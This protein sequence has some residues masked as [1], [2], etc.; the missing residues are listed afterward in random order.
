MLSNINDQALLVFPA[1][2]QHAVNHISWAKEQGIR[3]V[4]ASSDVDTDFWIEKENLII[5]PYIYSKDFPDKFLTLIYNENVGKIYSP[6]VSVYLWLKKFISD[7]GLR[8]RL[9]GDSP[10]KSEMNRVD[11]LLNKVRNFSD[12]ITDCSDGKSS[13]S[14][15]E[16][17][18]VFRMSEN[19][20]GESNDTKIAAMIAIFSSAPKGDV[21]EI[22]SLLGKSAAVLSLMARYYK[23]G[24]VLSID[25]WSWED[26]QQHDSPEVVS[27]C[28]EFC[29]D[30]EKLP[31]TFAINL[32]PIGL[33]NFNYMKLKSN[34]GFL[35]YK[36]EKQAISQEF[37]E[38]AY[39]GKISVIH[40]DGNHDYQQVKLDCDL[41]VPLI[42]SEGWL[43]IDDYRWAHGD[44]PFRAGNEILNKYNEQIKLAF[45]C[46]KALFITF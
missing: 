27:K 20:Y 24:N 8:I 3:V 36:E 29:W 17:A 40:I 21:I 18:A 6:V 44:G 45:T 10:T 41:W 19:I 42:T 25:P 46:G 12:F 30:L 28:M 4:V 1:I 7:N 5:L 26:S 2:N 13:L 38:I 14:L 39:A 43:I 31:T 15:I 37:G 33:G 16:I 23:V 22:G 9:I 34:Q 11:K 32:I 35:K